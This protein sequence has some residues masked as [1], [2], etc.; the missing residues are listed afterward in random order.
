MKLTNLE[1]SALNDGIN[2]FYQRG[3]ML[4]GTVSLGIKAYYALRKN[5]PKVQEAI[6]PYFE[7]RELLFD[8][9]NVERTPLPNGM[10]N[11]KVLPEFAEQ[12][13]AGMKELNEIE[14]EVE[15]HKCNVEEFNPTQNKLSPALLEAL[16]PM[17]IFEE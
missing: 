3:G 2:Q 6:T 11:L 4:I 13:N 16:E 15:I 9:C 17:L 14:V 5:K 1:L 8:K 10:M 7:A 12:Y